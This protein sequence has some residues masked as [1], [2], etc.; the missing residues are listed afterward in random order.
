MR[1]TAQ[2]EL[3]HPEQ[4]RLRQ[5]EIYY[6][7]LSEESGF[8]ASL[9][10]LYAI[11]DTPAAVIVRSL[12]R[13]REQ[14]RLPPRSGLADV[15]WTLQLKEEM[16]DDVILLS[17]LMPAPRLVTDYPSVLDLALAID[18]RKPGA[19][20]EA[21]WRKAKADIK[22]EFRRR[23]FNRVPP[24]HRNEYEMRRL[25]RRVVRRVIRQDTWEQIA[26]AESVARESVISSVREWA[27]TLGLV[28]PELPRGRPKK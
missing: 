9:D 24:Q 4:L 18:D 20:A 13:F 3:L 15:L 10:E 5:L 19:T 14:W 25:A 2:A 27:Q 22:A 23:G 26:Q 6:L 17:T 28:L 1:H 8:G 11:G 21:I 16:A 12:T 7:V